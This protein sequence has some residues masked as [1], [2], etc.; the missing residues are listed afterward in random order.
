MFEAVC[1]SNPPFNEKNA[2]FRTTPS[3]QSRHPASQHFRNR[4]NSIENLSD[5]P[6]LC[7]LFEVYISIVR[8]CTQSWRL[9]CLPFDTSD[10]L[11]ISDNR[12]QHYE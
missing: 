4:Q 3:R 6:R 10:Q 8:C 5:D 1:S 11:T 9:K 2:I 7:D 12:A